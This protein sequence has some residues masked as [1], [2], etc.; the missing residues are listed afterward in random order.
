MTLGSDEAIT[1]TSSG[2]AS[3]RR[4]E[5]PFRARQIERAERLMDEH[6]PSVRADEPLNRH[7]AAVRA[8]LIAALPVAPAID[9]ALAIELRPPFAEAQ[10]RSLSHEK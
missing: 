6:A 10:Q 7:A 1:N 9:D 3:L 8:Q 4:G 5:L 2:S